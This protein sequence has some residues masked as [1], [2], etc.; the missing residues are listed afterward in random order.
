MSEQLSGAST[1]PEGKLPAEAL[2]A[3]V[4][5]NLRANALTRVL[6]R[7]VARLIAETKGRDEAEV[8]AELEE[9]AETMFEE[10]RVLHGFSPPDTD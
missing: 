5:D 1:Q 7:H 9:E 3:I 4:T 8:F 10:L 2:G 6:H